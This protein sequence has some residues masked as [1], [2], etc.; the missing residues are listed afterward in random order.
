MG[1]GHARGREPGALIEGIH[2]K[3]HKELD[4]RWN[5]ELPWAG[6]VAGREKYTL[7]DQHPATVRTTADRVPAVVDHGD[8]EGAH[9]REAIF[10]IDCQRVYVERVF[11]ARRHRHRQQPSKDNEEPDDRLGVRPRRL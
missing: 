11:S 2:P 9:I 6:A 5:P 10:V 4:V 3:A 8:D 1:E 7:V